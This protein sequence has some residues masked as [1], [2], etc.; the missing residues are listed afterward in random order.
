[1]KMDVLCT[2]EMSVS[3][4]LLTG[5]NIPDV[6]IETFKFFSADVMISRTGN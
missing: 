2:S 6:T 5:P 3:I 1:M 4:Y